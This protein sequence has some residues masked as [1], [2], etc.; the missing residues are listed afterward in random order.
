MRLKIRCDGESEKIYKIFWELNKALTI[1]SFIDFSCCIFF[2]CHSV[3]LQVFHGYALFGWAPSSFYTPQSEGTTKCD[4]SGLLI[5]F[6][7]RG[8]KNSPCEQCYY[9]NVVQGRA[10]SPCLRPC[11]VP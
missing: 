7:W 1:F 11:L 4:L 8:K 6:D 10:L 9:R 3:G 2:F 5:Y